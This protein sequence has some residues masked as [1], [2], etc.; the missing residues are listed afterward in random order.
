[1]LLLAVIAIGCSENP[2]EPQYS[3]LHGRWAWIRTAGGDDSYMVMTPASTKSISVIT[4]EE[5]RSFESYI[6][7]Q[8]GVGVLVGFRSD[9]LNERGYYSLIDRSGDLY[10]E[11]VQLVVSDNLPPQRYLKR[12]SRLAADTLD[13]TD[14]DSIG[15]F[16]ATYARM[17]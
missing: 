4:L 6:A 15:P 12:V 14:V 7:F 13:L 8:K 1:V 2:L 5:H 3:M 9:S 11:F 16:T 10:I 17:R